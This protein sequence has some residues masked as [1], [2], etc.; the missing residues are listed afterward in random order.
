MLFRHGVPVNRAAL[1]VPETDEYAPYYG[2]YISQ[3]PAGDLVEV[4]E[5][6]AAAF[7]G[8]LGGLDEAAANFRY[9][10]GKWTLKEIVGH[11]ADTERVFVY[12]ALSLARGDSSPLPGVEPDAWMPQARFQ[13]RSLDGLLGEWSAVRQ[14][15]LAFLRGLPEDIDFNRG[16]ASGCPFSVRALVYVVPGHLQ[17]HMAVIR[18]RYLS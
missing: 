11:L 9:A 1:L 4:M 5:A 12:R 6:Q 7:T 16:M 14:A 18:E 3:V 13:D 17:H 2:R 10:P 15:S 8:C